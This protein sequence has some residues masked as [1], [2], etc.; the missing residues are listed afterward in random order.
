[1]LANKVI[2]GYISKCSKAGISKGAQASLIGVSRTTL[3]N[4]DTAMKEG[5]TIDTLTSTLE[6]M[7]TVSHEI[8]RLVKEGRLPASDRAQR[9]HVEA[10]LQS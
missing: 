3:V 9:K 10:E 4:W 1:M 7:L 6:K 8:D 2:S 5:K